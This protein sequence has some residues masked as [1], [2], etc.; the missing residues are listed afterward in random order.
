MGAP[1]SKPTPARRSS[2]AGGDVGGQRSK[3]D[4]S[5]PTS[6]ALIA[7]RRVGVDLGA[8]IDDRILAIAEPQHARVA[9]AQLLAAGITPCAI[10]RRVRSGRL[11]P[12]HLG[13]YGLA[14]TAERPL[15]AEAVALLACGADAL[16]SHHSAATL[17]RLRAGVARP[18]HVTIPGHR[19][20][21][22][23]AGVVVHRCVTLSATDIATCEGLPITSPARTV[24]DVAAT[25][26]DREVEL[27]LDE[28]L[29]VRRV[30]TRAQLR[31]LL[32][33]AGNHPGRARLARVLAGHSRSTKT[34]S[35]PE[36]RMLALIRAAALPEPRTQVPMLDYLLDFF[37]PELGLALEV[38]AYGTHGSRARFES[39]RRRDA[40]L[41]TEKAIIVLRVT[42]ASMGQRPFEAVGL[43]A[44]AIGQREAVVARAIGQ[45]EAALR[46]P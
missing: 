46:E 20:R 11:E 32:A 34:D 23:P 8:S 27:V 28:G 30:L 13:V 10:K 9:R 17:W 29:F 35:P 3:N 7:D 43:V 31:E 25:V 22:S 26:G 16:L 21:G 37:W 40:R 1:S 38:D 36:E 44:R 2:P 39:D 42:E 45:R 12:I 33:R 19:G 41:L 14:H 15:G 24:L 6:V 4:P 5:T 18:V